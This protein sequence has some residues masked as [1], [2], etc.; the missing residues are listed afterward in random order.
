M[1]LPITLVLA[2]ITLLYF[3]GE[4]LVASS[5]RLARSFGISRIV[6][7]LTVVAFATSSPELAATLT[8]AFRGS[9]DIA[10]GNVLGSNIANLGLILGIAA[11]L[12]P[13]HTHIGFIRREV[14]FMI[15]A[16]ALVYP[17]MWT[18]HYL[19]RLEGLLLVA[20]LVAVLY[21]LVRDPE[22]QQVVDDLPDDIA[23]PAWVSSLGVLGGIALLVGGA[24]A[25]IS[26]ASEIAFA[27]GV[28]ERVIGL[29]MVA[30]GTSL[31]ELAATLVAARRHESDL[32]LGNVIGSNIFNLLCVL[33]LTAMIHPI[34]VVPQA[35]GQDF[36]VVLGISV[37][38]LVMLV[39]GKK[40]VRWEGVVLLTIYASYT[41]FLYW[42]RG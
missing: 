28:P 22:S 13:L 4:V 20:L 33:G 18:G 10:V 35:L 29:T 2:G 3:G 15:F 9:P 7:G 23:W 11:V 36:W 24:Q 30:L 14:G 25:L 42:P 31:P 34:A 8:A 27:F 39:S 41:A 17:L 21:V 1:L 40:V 37:L 16:T 26:G 32:V 38:T 5:I 6:I 12:F 19:G